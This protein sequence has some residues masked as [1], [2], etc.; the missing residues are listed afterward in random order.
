[1]K[2]IILFVFSVYT[3]VT[4][5]KKK[6]IDPIPQIDNCSDLSQYKMNDRQFC[7]KCKE[8]FILEID[9]LVKCVKQADSHCQDSHCEICESIGCTKCRDNKIAI[10]NIC[11]DPA[12]QCHE[13]CGSCAPDKPETCFSCF[14]GFAMQ[15]EDEATK[16]TKCVKDES[17]CAVTGPVPEECVYCHYGFMS[18]QGK[19]IPS[20]TAKKK[21][22]FF[23]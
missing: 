12:N 6:K 7:S 18:R 8:G 21:K 3:V 15:L 13:N 14:P 4:R 10:N 22:F 2:F 17:N 20:G 16:K 1:M 19:C 23:F 11:V 5:E 9:D